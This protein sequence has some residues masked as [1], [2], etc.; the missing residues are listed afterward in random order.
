MLEDLKPLTKQ[1]IKN[2]F[3]QMKHYFYQIKLKDG[4]FCVGFF[5]HIKYKNKLI[6]VLIT[7]IH[8]I[9]EI[10]NNTLNLTINKIPKRILLGEARYKNSEY[11]LAI[12]EIKENRKDNLNFLDID[13]Q[14]YD[15][16][17]G[18]NYYKESVYIIHYNNENDILINFD[19][20][21]NIN[22]HEVRTICK[23]NFIS[24]CS[25]IFN[26]S[27]NKIIGLS[28]NCSEK[29]NKSISFKFL[30]D[31]FNERY[32]FVEYINYFKANDKYNYNQNFKNEIDILIKVDENDIGKEIY[33]LDN[34]EYRDKEGKNHC[35]DNLKELDNLN[36]EIY[37][38]KK[39]QEYKKYFIPERKGKYKIKIKFNIKLTDC[40]Y[41]FA[42]C[43]NII[44]INFISFNTKYITNMKYM[45]HLCKNLKNINLYSL[46]TQNVSDISDMFS[47]C[48]N[49]IKLDLSSFNTKNVINMDYLFYHCNNL[50]YLDIASV[51]N[52]NTVNMNYAF[53]LCNNLSL[54]SNIIIKKDIK[55]KYQNE[56]EIII[57]IDKNDIKKGIYFIDNFE[58]KDNE[59]NIHY[60]DNLTELNE[61]NTELY[62]NDIKT[63]Y[64]KYFMPK[65]PGKYNIKIKFNIYLTDCSY[66]FAGCKNIIELNFIS[67][68]TQ[69]ITN[70]KAMFNSC[71]NLKYIK[72]LSSFNTRNVIN[73]SDMFCH[74]YELND[75]DLS[76]FNCQNTV[77]IS[78]MF[79][80]CFNL[81]NIIFSDFNTQ[82]A[83]DMS[84]M[85]YGCKHLNSLNLSSFITKN[86][87]DMSYMFNGCI[88]LNDIK[89]SSFDTKNVTN[90]NCMFQYCY[91]LTNLDLSSFDTTNVQNISGMFKYCHNLLNLNISSFNTQN[92]IDMS[93]LFFDCQCLKYLNVSSFNTKNVINMNNMF[94][95]CNNLITLDLSSFDTENVND[96][97]GM[98]FNCCTLK[99]L[100]LS[101]FNTK[102]VTNMAEMFCQCN[103]LVNLDLSSFDTGN[104]TKM[105]GM[106]Y[107]CE[108]LNNL[109]LSSFNTDKTIDIKGIF[110]G[111]QKKIIDSNKSIFKKFNYDDFISDKNKTKVK[112]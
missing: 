26:L 31:E 32:E 92:V 66:M 108:N 10:T 34:Y 37:I 109:N 106:F 59:G 35:H 110:H 83:D 84:Y 43:E 99:K 54:S 13:E 40:S 78:G 22:N 55:D 63:G 45:F 68:N 81:K 72:N 5:S 104:V 38:K 12:I 91:K 107:K 46:E 7:S 88:N 3:E 42:G 71:N 79:F 6:P 18:K 1:G 47:F 94:C 100:D 102:K 2:I 75:L 4:N 76:L 21:D 16:F 29:T 30:I 80:N 112:Y 105:D 73:M 50:K 51:D 101:K 93:N 24:K 95:Q 49:L 39:E 111:C 65:K 28:K 36:T 85:F 97:G 52:I 87:T 86:V 89:L 64:K 74:C 58:Y 33:F 57:N 77:D 56:I 90:M 19:I 8:V 69:L 96:M 98:F 25:P 53:E 27:N 67:F 48:E 70:M 9:K 23:T 41:M 17:F 11:D 82:K 15:I 60:H 103:N 61:M 20:I 44:D 14:L 62:I